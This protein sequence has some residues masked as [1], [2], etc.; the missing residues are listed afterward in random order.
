MEVNKYINVRD[1]VTFLKNLIEMESPS[2]I[3]KYA[4]ARFENEVSRFSELEYKD[5][6]NN[7]AY[8]VGNGDTKILFSGHI[9][10]V[11]ARISHISD[12]GF[13]SIINVGGM[14]KKSLIGSVVTILT[15]DGFSYDA[16]VEKKPIHCEEDDE[17]NTTEDFSKLRLSTGFESREEVEAHGIHIGSPV[18]YNKYYDLH[19]GSNQMLAP[20]L[21]DKIGVFIAGEILKALSKTPDDANWRSKYTVIGLAAT[22]E[23]TGCRGAQVA[24]HNINPDISIDFDVTFASD[25]DTGVDKNQVGDIQL[26][27]G[28]VIQYGPDKS[29]RLNTILAKVADWNNIP[30]Q[31]RASCVGGTNTNMFQLRSKDCETTLISIPNRNMHTPVELCDWRDVQSIVDICVSAI[32]DCSL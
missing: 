25:G 7:V 5:K 1:D 22:Q 12:K 32:E 23:E 27:K 11:S 28:G 20:G 21:D 26:G 17:R 31:R 13:I 9:D 2:G 6:M 8:K 29:Q 3:E 19:F 18:I 16:V 4:A 15:D 24:A 14:C 30:Y 10:E